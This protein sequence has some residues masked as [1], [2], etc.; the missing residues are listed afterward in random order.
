MIK[1]DLNIIYRFIL[2][3]GVLFLSDVGNAQITLDSNNFPIPGLSVT[4]YY[5]VTDG[6]IID[7]LGGPG[8]DQNYDFSNVF[9]IPGYWMPPG[10]TNP[11]TIDYLDPL[12]TPF[13]DDHPGADLALYFLEDGGAQYD[14]FSFDNDA[15]WKS[16]NATIT[17]YGLGLDTIHANYLP[18]DVDTILSN[19]YSYGHTE[20]ENSLLIQNFVYYSIPVEIKSYTI[21]NI[22]VDGW[23]TLSTPFTFFDD[24]LRIKYVQYQTDSFFIYGSYDSDSV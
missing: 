4:R 18:A 7:S 5:A 3:F 21:R 12:N 16:G 1:T 17:D 2:I 8:A 9:I 19:Q 15:Y 20:T 24:V 10:M 14:Y 13:A 23:G 22:S 6:M 11:D